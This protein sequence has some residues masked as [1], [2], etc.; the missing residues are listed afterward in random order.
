MKSDRKKVL[1]SLVFIVLTI[2]CV[3]FMVS[4]EESF[5]WGDFLESIKHSSL[6][7]ILC[8]VCSMVGFIVFEAAAL[9]TIIRS[10]GYPKG[11]RS[12]IVYS[13]A[14]IYFSAI[15]PSATGGQPV[16]AFFMMADGIPG[17]VVT[18]SLILNL[19]AYTMAIVFVGVVALLFRFDIFLEF[20]L[21]SKG[22]IIAGFAVLA[23]M[24]AGFLFLLRNGSFLKRI[25]MWFIRLGERLKIVK[26]KPERE[27]KIDRIV[28]DYKACTSLFGDKKYLIWKVF[29]WD[30]M[31][32]AS[33][34]L[35]SVFVYL[36]MGGSLENGLKVWFIQSFSAIGSNCVPIPGAIGVADH[37]MLEGYEMVLP[38]GAA[39]NMELLSRGI[40]FYGSVLLSLI[41]IIPGYFGLKSMKKKS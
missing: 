13:A 40:S 4:R 22:L 33:Q 29:F 6:P 31:Q 19:V 36:A 34:I 25:I 14:D 38:H 5:F 18:A 26:K 8:A 24:L 3:W 27:Q 7:L 39:L 20:S 10:V 37:L 30:L 1:W 32:R 9:R 21:V 16:S 23:V 17:A 12:N 35:V 2:L 28:S 15:T 41:I 11:L